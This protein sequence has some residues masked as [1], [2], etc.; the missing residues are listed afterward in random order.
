MID[1]IMINRRWASSVRECRS[2]PEADISSDHNLVLCNLRIA[3]RQRDINN[4]PIA[5]VDVSKLEDADT[6][7]AYRQAVDDECDKL[8]LSADINTALEQVTTAVKK[9]ATEILGTKRRTSKPWIST[10]TL[11]L[12]DEKR[13]ARTK[14]HNSATLR[15]AYNTLCKLTKESAKR[16]KTKWIQEQCRTIQETYIAG[17]TREAYKVIGAVKKK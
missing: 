7:N 11:K 16:D 17:R 3:L 1:M 12:A 4:K 10:E 6:A 13:I 9:I 5:P 2:F 15:R 14:R 8:E